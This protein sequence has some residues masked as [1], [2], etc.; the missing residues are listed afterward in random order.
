[1]SVMGYFDGRGRQLRMARECVDGIGTRFEG[2]VLTGEKT[3]EQGL[4]ED[5]VGRVEPREPIYRNVDEYDP[6]LRS[7]C[8]L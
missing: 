7:H 6:V 2:K 4:V 8:R 3:V 5:D 1:M